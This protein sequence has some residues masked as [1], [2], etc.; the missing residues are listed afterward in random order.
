MLVNELSVITGG[1]GAVGG[2]GGGRIQ[3]L[4]RQNYVA[5]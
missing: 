5:K 2:G 3:H 4:R 1:G